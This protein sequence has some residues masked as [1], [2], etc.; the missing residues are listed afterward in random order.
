MLHWS[1][2]YLNLKWT[3]Y[4]CGH[5]C[6]LILKKE[7]NIDLVFDFEVPKDNKG[8]SDLVKNQIPFFLADKQ[9]KPAEYGACI[10]SS[11]TEFCHVGITTKIGSIWHIIHT[12]KYLDKCI[13]TPLYD[14]SL[15]GLRAK[16]FYQWQ[17]LL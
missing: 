1:C 4:D 5:I 6:K 16:G 3:D 8:L 7:K 13:R 10:M 2:K 17:K 15:Y 9:D 11:D 12:V 14:L